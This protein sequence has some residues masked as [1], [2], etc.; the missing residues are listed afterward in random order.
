[1]IVLSDRLEKVLRL[2]YIYLFGITFYLLDIN[3]ET[4][5]SKSPTIVADISKDV[6]A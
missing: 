5:L 2:F 6:K 3:Q 4:V 1:M